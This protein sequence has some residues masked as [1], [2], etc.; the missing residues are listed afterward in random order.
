[1]PWPQVIKKEHC[2][3]TRLKIKGVSIELKVTLKDQTTEESNILV[4]S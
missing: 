4:L 1:M 2:D 3:F